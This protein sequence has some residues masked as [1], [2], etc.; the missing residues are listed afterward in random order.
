MLPKIQHISSSPM[1][2]AFETQRLRFVLCFVWLRSRV[3]QINFENAQ[4]APPPP[5]YGKH[6]IYETFRIIIII[7]VH[8]IYLFIIARPS[9]EECK[10][11]KMSTERERILRANLTQRAT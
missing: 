8:K 6:C 11:E 5:K 10:R 9:V 1:S 4:K 7:L 2:F 3:I